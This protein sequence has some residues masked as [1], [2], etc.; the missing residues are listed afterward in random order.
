MANNWDAV[1][2]NLIPVDKG[3]NNTA[4]VVQAGKEFD[5][6]ADVE[7]GPNINGFAKG[8]QLFV[9]V[10]NLSQSTT[11]FQASPSR[12][13]P[14]VEQ[15]LNDKLRVTVPTGWAGAPGDLLEIVATY[16]FDA[17]AYTDFSGTTS[18]EIIAT[19]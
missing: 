17:G 15:P 4:D 6:V 14:S 8:D 1:I 3:T 19:A 16:R 12:T 7:A 2:N 9:A 11:V 10:R 5:I 13:L 18:R